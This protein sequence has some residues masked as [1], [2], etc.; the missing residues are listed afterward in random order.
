[1]KQEV[2]ISAKANIVVDQGSTFS[3]YLN[4]TDSSGNTINLTGVTASGQVR[5]WYTS[6]SYV[7]FNISIPSPNTGN[8]N[9]ALSSNTTANM[10]PG[11][12]VY[13]IDT[14]DASGNVTRVVEGILTITPAV[15][16]LPGVSYASGY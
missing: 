4:L 12:Y 10:S 15:T 2:V 9:I 1:M 16:Q 7:S 3:T 11:R 13:D 5:S 8:I 6:S 14:V